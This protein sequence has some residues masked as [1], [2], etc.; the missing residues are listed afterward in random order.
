MSGGISGQVIINED[1]NVQKV[2]RWYKNLKA[3]QDEIEG[4]SVQIISTRDRRKMEEARSKFRLRYPQYN[5]A[6]DYVEP[7]YRLR[8]GRFISK[9]DALSLRNEVRSEFRSTLLIRQNFKKSEFY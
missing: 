8:V 3:N 7:F 6:T 5:I 2:I 9:L 4:W 1:P